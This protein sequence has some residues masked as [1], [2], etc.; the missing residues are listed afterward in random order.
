MSLHPGF[1]AA[2]AHCDACEPVPHPVFFQVEVVCM[3]VFCAEYAIRLVTS[4]RM[5]TELMDMQA[6]TTLACST[7]PLRLLTPPL[8]VVKFIFAP[9]NIIDLVAILPFILEFGIVRYVVIDSVSADSQLAV[10]RVIR[11]TRVFRALKLGKYLEAF[12]ILGRAL[13]RSLKALYV[14]VFYLLLGVVICSSIVYLLELGRWDPARQ[15]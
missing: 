7:T 2:P 14:L 12:V 1:R 4:S 3:S 10:L 8:R 5:R 6:L 9:A 11:L 13:V 15:G